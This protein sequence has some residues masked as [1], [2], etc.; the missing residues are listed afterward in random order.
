MMECK[1]CPAPRACAP[2]RPPRGAGGLCLPGRQEG[3]GDFLARGPAGK[4]KSS[5]HRGEGAW[6]G[7]SSVKAEV[8]PHTEHPVK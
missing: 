4:D 7:A 2:A 1:A 3:T 6:E 8:A 5:G